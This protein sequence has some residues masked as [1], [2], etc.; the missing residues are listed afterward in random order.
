MRKKG[1]VPEQTKVS[2]DTER[3]TK[4]TLVSREI[5]RVAPEHQCEPGEGEN[6]VCLGYDH[7][8]DSPNFLFCLGSK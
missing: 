5:T 4:G 3:S 1:Q 8:G 7:N 6:N 2:A